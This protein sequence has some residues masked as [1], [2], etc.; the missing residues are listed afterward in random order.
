MFV[1]TEMIQRCAQW[2]KCVIKHII[3]NNCRVIEISHLILSCCEEFLLVH[4][5]AHH[6]ILL[7]PSKDLCL[8]VIDFETIWKGCSFVILYRVITRSNKLESRW[9]LPFLKC[10][11]L[12]IVWYLSK[13]I[14]DQINLE[15]DF[16]LLYF[17]DNADKKTIFSWRAICWWY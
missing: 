9:Y 17:P 6:I 2:W 14:N 13:A 15:L 7:F 1:E 11:H 10:S 16:P 3:S 4:H 8:S 12:S 5:I